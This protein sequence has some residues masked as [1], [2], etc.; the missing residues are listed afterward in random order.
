VTPHSLRRTYASILIAC[1]EDPIYAARQMG[2]STPHLTM[3]VYA[4]MMERRDGERE[5]LKTLVAGE[6][7]DELNGATAPVGGVQVSEIPART[8][9]PHC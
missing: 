4:Q 8:G 3:T 6:S 7:L 9:R 1:G 5:R 2:H